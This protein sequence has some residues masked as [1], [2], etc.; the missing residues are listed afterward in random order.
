MAQ[1]PFRR[2]ALFTCSAFFAVGI[3]LGN[4]LLPAA[5]RIAGWV[6]LL[7][8]VGCGLFV[9]RKRIVDWRWLAVGLIALGAGSLYLLAWQSYY[10]SLAKGWPEGSYTLEG[11]ILS[12]VT[13]G[14]GS[15]S[16]YFGDLEEDGSGKPGKIRVFV[17]HEAAD[18]WR[19][20]DRLRMVNVET[21]Q[22][23]G[24]RNPGGYD[25]R[26]TIWANGAQVQ[27]SNPRQVCWLGHDFGLLDAPDMLRERMLAYLRQDM[28]GREFG[29]LKGML[30]GDVA[31]MDEGWLEAYRATGVAHVLA[32]SGLH[33]GI[34]A[35]A[36]EALFKK[37]PWK[38]LAFLL[39]LLATIFY[40]AMCGF[41]PSVL[42]AI[43]LFAL[44]RVAG[45]IGEKNDS[46]TSLGAAALLLLLLNP[47]QLFGAGFLLSF[48]AVLGL[49]LF[50]KPILLLLG[51][52]PITPNGWG[53]KLWRWVKT[54]M[55]ASAA[56]QLGIMPV[57]LAFFGTL[58]L[59]SVF[60]NLFVIPLA[61]A[62]VVLGLAAGLLGSVAPFLGALPRLLATLCLRA[63]NALTLAA[64]DIPG[65]LIALGYPDALFLTG[66]FALC[67]ALLLYRPKQMRWRRRLLVLGTLLCIASPA[68][69]ALIAR[70]RMEVVFLD[71]GQGDA[72]YLRQ[73]QRRMLVD[74][75]ARLRYTDNMGRETS[76]D[77]GKRAV[78]PF[79][80]GQGVNYLDAMVVSHGDS[81]HCG[82][83]L[84]VLE[85]L[86]VGLLVTGP[87]RPEAEED[88]TLDPYGE[89]L[90]AAEA[91][92]VPRVILG[93]GDA[94]DLGN[95]RV[96]A[97]WP[98]E[99]GENSNENS[100]VLVVDY[101]ESRSLF[102]GDA[103]LDSEENYA[104]GMG[105]IDL[106]K[107]SHH[108]SKGG[109]GEAFLA[110]GRPLLSVISAGANNRYGHPAPEVL[111]RL[112]A[113]G[114]VV[115]DTASYGAVTVFLTEEGSMSLRTEKAPVESRAAQQGG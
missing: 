25:P 78:L 11:R 90:A 79:L 31:D 108:G 68:L 4:G 73:G 39:T 9:W 75:G 61:S 33:V 58:P 15:S 91:R 17:S 57:Q 86:E 89:L 34:V 35:T 42:R 49:I 13:R 65:G 23:Q 20:G 63:M 110:E 87:D 43:L 37:L 7:A 80:R 114:S 29:A 50:S 106:L 101:G 16:F 10:D 21:E 52:I 40:G 60:L 26:M 18:S 94:F 62:A 38:R 98:R 99:A 45:L 30:F 64:A 19:Q 8:G 92:G 32:V 66:F 97:L 77:Y 47:F 70:Q 112:A 36:L 111:A 96:T 109:T 85:N 76:M 5:A 69:D 27:V 82:G 24:R 53:G 46:L 54:A 6:A 56:A 95:A 100:L 67:A 44:S 102:T 48:S 103:G 2:R 41:R 72:A 113:S 14:D 22:P 12:P 105:E 104:P 93:E 28:D 1:N 81:D 51:K 3:V 55:A 59:F 71:V 115:L 88:G 84:A 83:L 74:G 107:V